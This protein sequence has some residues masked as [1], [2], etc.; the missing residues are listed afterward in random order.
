MAKKILFICCLLISLRLQSQTEMKTTTGSVTIENKLVSLTFNLEKGI[1][2]VKNL[3]KNLTAVS[4]AYF[5]AEG[6]YSTDTTGIIEWSYQGIRDVFGKGGTLRIKKKYNGYSD[7]VWNATI[8][9]DKDFVVFKMGIINDSYIPF[10]LSAFYPLKTKG[11]CKGMDTGKNFAVLNGNSGGNRTYVSESAKTCCFNN[12]LIRFGELNDPKIIVAGGLTYNEFE[13][14]CKVF[15]NGDSLGIQLF[16]EDP[17]GKLIDAGSSW[18]GNELFYLCINNLNPFEALEKYGLAVKEAQQIK[19]NYYDFP[20][21]CLWYASVYAKDPARPK[22][23]DSKGAVDEMENAVRSGFTKYTRVA[24]RLVPD[25]YGKINQQGWWDDKHWAMWGDVS[26]ADSTNYCAP[27][28]TTA[29][30]CRKILDKGGIP[31]TYFQS[32]RRSEDFVKENPSFMLFND[33]YRMATGQADKMKHLNYDLGGESDEGYLNQWWDEENMVGYDFTD[34]EFINHMKNV[35]K[36]L[37][38]AGIRG[39]MFDYPESTAWAFNGGFDDKYST[40]ASAYRN[41]LELAYEGLGEDSYI[42]ERMIGRGSDLSLGLIASQR[43]W[44]D[45]DLFMPEMVTRCGLRWYKNRV[46]VNYDLD[47]KDPVKARPGYNNDGLKTLMTMCYVV[48]ARF[49]MA[50]GFYQLSPEQLYIMSRTFPYHTLPKSSRPVDAFSNGF[51]VPRIF[52]YEVNPGWHQLTLYN[53]NLDS[54]NNDDGTKFVELGRSLN[55][56]GLGLDPDKEYFLYD[57]WND[58]FVGRFYGSDNV[59]QE[60]RPGETRMISIHAIEENPQFISTNR[61]IM[62]GLVDM[63]V[64]PA[65]NET[66]KV[67]T[68]KSS[69]IGGEEY[70]VVIALNGFKTLKCSAPNARAKIELTDSEKNLAVLSILSVKNSDIEW[71]IS[72]KK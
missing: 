33:P 18:E 55:E 64:L 28:L 42:D 37:K 57:Y 52:D 38:N 29:S 49:L 58:K 50:R 3:P 65:W 36:N 17:V 68:G 66:N 26:S 72:F 40:T 39:L 46:V 61:H 47:A 62:Q 23:N 53:P 5:Q 19:L 34:E 24:I 13:K 22:F 70:K 35:Y 25:A 69:V 44:G 6:L 48:S 32:G 27:Y 30:W 21:E 4:N 2:S 54:T 59:V 7:M 16:S 20:T 14:F 51:T 60:L 10:R 71:S 63:K 41:M 12:V 9:D 31:L 8:Y 11:S 43:V 67:L 56:G 1:Y 15:R 45:N